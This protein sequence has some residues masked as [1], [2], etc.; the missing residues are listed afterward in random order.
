MSCS[1]VLSD[2]KSQRPNAFSERCG[3][4]CS[5]YLIMVGMRLRVG[6]EADRLHRLQFL[7]YRGAGVVGIAKIN[8]D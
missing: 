5:P 7:A 1:K 8:L 3:S 4:F 6:L 2:T